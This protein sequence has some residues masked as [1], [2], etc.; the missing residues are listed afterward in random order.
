MRVLTYLVIHDGCTTC[1]K[2]EDNQR[3]WDVK[4]MIKY[5]NPFSIG[6]KDID[7]YLA[8]TKDGK[9]LAMEGDAVEMLKTRLVQETIKD[10]MQQGTAMDSTK[11]VGDAAFGFPTNLT[12]GEIH[13]L[14]IVP[15][16]RAAEFVVNDVRFPVTKRMGLYPPALVAFWKALQDYSTLVVADA[17]LELPVGA[18]LLGYPA[19]GLKVYIRPCYPPLWKVCWKLIQDPKSPHL[20]ILGNPGIGKTFFGIFILLQ[21]ARE[22]KTVVYESGA[23]MCRY[24]FSGDTVVEGTQNDFVAFLRLPTTY[25]IVDAVK[26]QKCQAMTILLTSPRHEVWFSFNN[27]NC[28]FRYMPVWTLDEILSC[29]KLLYPDLD[30]NMVTDCF[31]RWGGVPRYVLE[32]MLRDTHQSLLERALGMVNCDWVVNAIGELDAMFEASHRL[33]HYDVN[34]KTFINKHVVFASPYVQDVVYRRLCKD[35][36]DKL[37]KFLAAS[38]GIDQLGVV[39]GIVFE[40]YVHAVLPRGGRFRIRRLM[41]EGGSG[42]ANNVDQDDKG[43]EDEEKSD[44]GAVDTEG[45]L[46]AGEVMNKGEGIAFVSWDINEARGIVEIPPQQT[47]MFDKDNEV[48]S[49][50]SGVYLRPKNKN[51]PS[52]DAIVKPDILLQVTVGA[53]HPCKQRGLDSAIKLLATPEQPKLVFV[54]PPDRFDDFKHQRY[55]TVDGRTTTNPFVTLRNIKQYAMEVTL[56]VPSEVTH[57]STDGT[58]KG[59]KRPRQNE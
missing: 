16:W 19:L 43:G 33:L 54:L 23:S 2:V 8:K 26:P 9:W 56:A 17:I 18:F 38:E 13:V 21:L 48:A 32:N 51:Y 30:V 53:T 44:D 41:P 25:Y 3:V 10:I 39:R 36:H 27:D 34:E 5:D 20:V 37:V 57:T 59:V 49:A 50:P 7:L 6:A 52:V 4:K 1:L 15:T 35:D 11:T 14:V 42:D 12:A 47:V 46:G 45:D 31:H 29:R 40:R 24:L 58:N 55:V 28:D 22:N